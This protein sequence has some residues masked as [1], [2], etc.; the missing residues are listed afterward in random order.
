[1]NQP[2]EST[3]LPGQPM[4]ET[5]STARAPA[6][7]PHPQ[8]PLPAGPGQA[9]DAQLQAEI[10]AAMEGKS[11]EQL[12]DESAPVAADATPPV[13]AESPA[14]AGRDVDHFDA[15]LVRGR[16]NHIR[17]DDVFVELS[18]L[19]GKNQGVVPLVQFE[20]PP[21]VGSIMDFVVQREDAAEGLLILS[22]EGAV[23]RA[24]WDQLRRG[25]VAEARVVS[26]NKGGLELELV[27][28][29]RA[30]M[31]ASQIDL[32]H[33]TD[34]EQFVGQK[35][36]GVVMEIDRKGKKVL[37]SRRQHLINEREAARRKT[38]AEL[39]VGQVREGTISSVMDYGAFV[40]LGGVDGLIHVSDLSYA[41]V[42]K[43][44]SV[45]QV[46]QK[47]QVK[48]LKIDAEKG[49][50]GL[51][52]KQV[53]PD[54]WEG[55]EGRYQSGQVV[56]GRVTRLAPFGA[57]VELEAGVEGLVPIGELSWRRIHQPGDVLKEGESIR[58]SVLAVDPAKHRLTL[59]VKQAGGDPWMGAVVK[60]PKH[61][62]VQARVLSTTDF[63]AFV[64]IEPGVEGLV[65]ISE[66]SD[67][68]VGAVTD[69]MQPGQTHELRILEVDEDNR[70]MRLSLKAVKEPV[71]TEAPAARAEGPKT[72]SKAA[73]PAKPP[74][75]KT[76]NPN[77]KSGLGDNAAL[78]L[79]LGQL[80]L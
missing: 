64:E 15:Q 65:H 17:G 12:M 66:L 39:E 37:L 42:D 44:A 68:R 30:F 3:P 79:G 10:D 7:V 72:D 8:P 1:M 59:S 20:R 51:G 61:G 50:I 11:V 55:I 34:M 80:R 19:P 13:P 45:V 36:P 58:C 70:R 71:P 35:L 40:D 4:P 2:H 25:A 54:P 16:I 27:G 33:V 49:R 63:G 56:G 9:I 48:V 41:R 31:P 69:V 46:G 43:P 28:N 52:L 32:H 53:A 75:K 38:L 60:Y 29:I 47:V 22:R 74:A 6:N 73:A 14:H 76:R 67:K 21:R 5:T 26:T 62:L 77:L 23:G 18:G 24:T 78:G 57:F